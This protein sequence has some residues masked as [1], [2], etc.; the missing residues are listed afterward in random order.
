MT[1]LFMIYAGSKAEA[2][3]YFDINYDFQDKELY[4]RDVKNLF[5]MDPTYK[6][7]YGRKRL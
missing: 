1:F 6:S 3:D 4:R 5:A 7:I 2:W